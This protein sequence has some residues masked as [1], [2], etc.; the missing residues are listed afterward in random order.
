MSQRAGLKPLTRE[1]RAHSFRIGRIAGIDIRIHF[2]F[3]LLVGLF[4]V[5]GTAPGGPGALGAVLWLAII[6]GCVIVHELAHCLVGRSRGAVVHEI[7]LLPIGGVSKLEKLP[8]GPADEFAMAIAGP[9][10]SLGIAIGAALLALVFAQPVLPVDMFGGPLLARIMWFNLLVAAFNLLPAFPL[11]GG[12]V[13]RALLERRHDLETATRVA[14]RVGRWM[15]IVFIAFGLFWN[16]WLLI[17][18]IFVYFGATAE[19]AATIV[20]VR[21]A[22]RRVGDV[23][24]LDPVTVDPATPDA[25][26]RALVRHSAQR[27]FPVVGPEGYE[28]IVDADMIEHGDARGTVADVVERAAPVVAATDGLEACLPLVVSVP[29]RALAVVDVDGRVVGLLRGEDITR[30]LERVAAARA[31][32]NGSIGR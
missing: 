24:L 19:E 12:R 22:R 1:R 30:V 29:A 15:A 32:T 18:G 3:L 7:E 16:I 13:F 20:H 4:A 10:A 2:T 9:A 23:M 21:L 14:A 28:G 5:A 25:D 27:V 31:S 6:F 11:D 17:I 26:F 8:E